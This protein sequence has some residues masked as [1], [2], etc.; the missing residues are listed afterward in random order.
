MGEIVQITDK[1]FQD[2]I[3]SSPMVLIDFFA[4][5]C[6]PCHTI[7]PI[8]EELAENYD[9]KVVVGKLNIDDNPNTAGQLQ[10]MSIPTVI[11]FKEGKPVERIVGAVPKSHLEESIQPHL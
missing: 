3:K 2:T 1:S 9:G 6:G 4:D 7:A 8:I 5:W 10:V 11:L